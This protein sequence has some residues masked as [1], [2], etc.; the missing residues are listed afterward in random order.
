MSIAF[1]Q[2]PK[3]V[4]SSSASVQ[5]SQASAQGTTW[6][7]FPEIVKRLHHEGIYIHPHQLAEF[8]LWHGLPVDADYVPKHLQKRA[9]AIN[10]NYQ[11]DMARLEMLNEQANLSPLE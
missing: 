11:G 1:I 5:Q 6:H 8:F 4:P 2:M 9:A 3:N 7:T 10:A